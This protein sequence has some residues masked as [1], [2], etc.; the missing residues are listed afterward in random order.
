MEDR[1]STRTVLI[2]GTSTGIGRATALHLDR[3]GW[4]VYAG[5][6]RDADADALRA[7]ATGRLT[8][9][10]L[11]VT[12]AASIEAAAEMVSAAVGDVGL[13]GLVNNAGIA[14]AAPVEFLPPEQFRRQFEV[15]VVGQIAVTQAMIPLLRAA[16][17]RIVN[18][19][20]IG[21][22][23]ASPMMAPYNASKFALEA[24]TD[25]LRVELR[26]WG[27]EVVA[28][29]PGAIATPIW[30]KS[31]AAA[32][33]LLAM[34]PAAAQEL[35]GPSIEAARRQARH[36]AA[37]GIA[38][39]AVARAVTHALSARRPR[40]RYVVGRDAQVGVLLARFMPDRMRDALLFRRAG[41]PR[42][43]PTTSVTPMTPTPVA[44]RPRP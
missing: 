35:Y 3:L 7:T 1:M 13:H 34:L 21:G 30:E 11:D 43:A 32:D 41:R 25:V 12:D 26:P 29:E 19:S 8:P 42:G 40:S 37:T 44:S 36:L 15:N 5:V 38:P 22:R 10:H 16:R 31:L 2:T 24:L 18:M 23:L 33:D 20:S 6:R 9:V 28:I 27:I 14:V 39:E 17:G 4:S